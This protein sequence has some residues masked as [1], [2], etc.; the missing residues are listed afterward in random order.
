MHL[1]SLVDLPDFI[2]DIPL[3]PVKDFADV[4]HHVNLRDVG[5]GCYCGTCFGGFDC[6]GAV[7]VWEAYHGTH[8]DDVPREL[9]LG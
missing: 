4:H 7:A 5:A 1:D 3:V 8:G 6:H 2:A 9:F